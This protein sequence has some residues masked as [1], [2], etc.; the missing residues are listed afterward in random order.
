MN[1]LGGHDRGS[2]AVHHR[3]SYGVTHLM[4]V[5]VNDR[6]FVG[7]AG[8]GTDQT[9]LFA[10]FKFR[11]NMYKLCEERDMTPA[12]FAHMVSNTLYEKRFGPFFCSPV[13][14]G[15]EPDDRPFLAGMDTIG[16]ME[17]AKDF[18]VAG[19]APESLYGVCESFWKPGMVRSAVR[20]SRSTTTAL[21]LKTFVFNIRFPP[22]TAKLSRLGNVTAESMVE[23]SKCA[24]NDCHRCDPNETKGLQS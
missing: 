4:C 1:S 13:I 19:T 2:R 20:Y 10:K 7:L 8:L 12:T 16:A 17:T 5:Q 18:M 3:N 15:L 22:I 24:S 14:A 6:L 21:F 23:M 11:H 9:T